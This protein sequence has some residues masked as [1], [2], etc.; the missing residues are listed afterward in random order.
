M[1][2]S[3]YLIGC[4]VSQLFYG[5]ISGRFGRRPIML[6]GALISVVGSLVC[7]F[8]FNIWQLISGRF[9]QAIGSCAGG[10]IASAAIRDAFP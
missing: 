5:P 6:S 9:I 7:L 4:V 1:T 2:M 10:V 3:S 8:S